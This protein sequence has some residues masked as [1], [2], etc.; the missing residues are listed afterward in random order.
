MKRENLNK[1]DFGTSTGFYSK[2]LK[3]VYEQI[4]YYFNGNLCLELGC[5]DGEGTKI[6]VKYFKSVVAV[7]GSERQ[8]EL[9]KQRVKSKKVKF[10][11]SYIEDL[12]LDMKFDTIVLAHILEHVDNPVLILQI[13]K[14][15]LNKGGIIIIDVPNA[16]SLHRQAGVLM[17]MLKN[18]YELNVSDKSV[19]HKRVYDFDLLEDDVKKSG[20]RIVRRSGVLIKPFSNSQL[21]KILDKKGVEAFSVLGLKYPEIA[22]E[23]IAICTLK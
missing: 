14:K 1:Y 21:D 11:E 2:T 15:M 17:G 3:N 10:I 23:I 6:L 7:D 8:I 4:A 20:L 5:A 18:E 12:D 22:A 9:A 13:A 19:G 16:L